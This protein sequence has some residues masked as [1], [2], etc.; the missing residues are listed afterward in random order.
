M[1]AGLDGIPTI[2]DHTLLRQ[3]GQ[4]SYGGVWLARNLVGTLR[5]V[6]VVHRSNFSEAHPF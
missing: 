1:G 3:I 2:P 5:A 4:G 6:K